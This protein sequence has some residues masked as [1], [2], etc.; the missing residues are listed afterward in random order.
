[1]ARVTVED[2][3]TRFPNQFEPV[4]MAARRARD[5]AGGAELSLDRDNDKNTV[6][7]LREI[8]E[9]TLPLE[10]LREALVKGHQRQVELMAGRHGQIGPPLLAVAVTMPTPR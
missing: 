3:V 1:M 9:R 8:A 4:M 2:C 10:E 5:V 6:V 7:A